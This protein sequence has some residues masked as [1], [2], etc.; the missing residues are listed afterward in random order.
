MHERN[1]FWNQLIRVKY[2]NIKTLYFKVLNYD[3][4]SSSIVKDIQHVD[5]DNSQFLGI[6]SSAKWK[7]KN[8]SL[9]YFWEDLWFGDNLLSVSFPHL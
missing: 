4:A 8:G 7:I 5:K 9:T 2:G 3:R 6:W 1:C